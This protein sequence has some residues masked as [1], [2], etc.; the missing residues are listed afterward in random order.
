M[1]L[2]QP[3]PDSA[4]PL[5]WL[6]DRAAISDLLIEYARSVDERDWDAFAALWADDA[7]FAL[8]MIEVRG[9]DAIVAA[10][11]EPGGVSQWDATHHINTNHEIRIDGDTATA[12]AYLIGTHVRRAQAPNE[13]SEGGGWYDCTFRRTPDGWRYASSRLSIT[14]HTGTDLPSQRDSTER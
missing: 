5:Q 10:A 7:I 13:H 4:E 2:P 6:L 9:R 12:R 14:W 11:S 3:P 1:S 8:P